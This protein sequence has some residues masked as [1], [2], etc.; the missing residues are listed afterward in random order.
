M[1]QILQRDFRDCGVTCLS[2]LIQFY[3]GYVPI[4]TLRDDTLTNQE[5]TN[6]YFLVETLKKYQFDSYGL[7]TTYDALKQFSLPAIL[8]VVLDNGMHHFV[9]LTKVQGNR[10]TLMDPA[11]GKKVLSKIELEHIWDGVILLAIPRGMIPRLPKPK[12]VFSHLFFLT[13]KENK[14]LVFL[15]LFGLFLA[16]LSI[17]TSF[18][19][20][21]GMQYVFVLEKKE[22]TRLL[23]A[24]GFLFFFKMICQYGK[25]SFTLYLD[26]N[27]DANYLFLFLSHLLKLPIF[28]FQSFHES[29]LLT[30]VEEAKEV[31]D[32]FLSIWITFSL[33]V[34]LGM[35]AFGVLFVI[36]WH[37][38]VLLFLGMFSYLLF[39]LFLMKPF[40]QVVL[41][42][43]ETKK[44][45]NE[46]V[47]EKIHLFLTMKHFHQTKMAL[48]NLEDS[49]CEKEGEW[50]YQKRKTLWF[51]ASKNFFL[52]FLFF[53]LM[54]YGILLVGQG[55]L[56]I[57]DFLTFQS[58]YFYFVNPLKEL[59]DI[60]PKFC[61][62]KGILR[63]IS[64]TMSLEE[65]KV[66]F[67]E[68]ILPPSIEVKDFSFSY[69]EIE[70][71][72]K[73]LSFKIKAKEHVFVD[74]PSGSGKSTF[75]KILNKELSG[76]LGS[77]T[78]SG[79][80]LEDYTLSEIRSSIVYLSQNEAIFSGTIREN[81]LFGCEDDSSFD[82]ICQIC[83]LEEIVCHKPLRYESVI[84][85]SSI[86]GGEKQRILLAR[87]LLQKGSLYLFDEA[88]SEVEE[89][90]ERK[91]ILGIRKQLKGKTVLYISHRNQGDAFERR[92]S[93]VSKK[94]RA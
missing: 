57:Y 11:S 79:K 82:L 89:E 36:E 81:I 51:Q 71:Q 33:E 94:R 78:L 42:R 41:E 59:A 67:K 25:E 77:I 1:K 18:Y 32:L 58:L 4:E 34:F 39:S 27:V 9:V 44:K 74:G 83:F 24:F 29:E 2:Y 52:E 88:L 76:Y 21:I 65:E 22:F 43:L 19:L 50:D 20:K 72:I 35:A 70:D 8:H 13:K 49:L 38:S 26:R 55:K 12:S 68:A 84:N 15:F 66:I 54:T 92:I 48:E 75:C 47:Y 28:K 45:W 23:I 40:Y 64:E 73:Q 30:R 56:T 63:K 69:N 14:L 31:K 3:H 7:K 91:I 87:A 46:M 16:I 60:A 80:D 85:E 17:L 86:S 53:L 61:Y 6:A 5:G 93:F 37:L 62:M 90:M 10:V